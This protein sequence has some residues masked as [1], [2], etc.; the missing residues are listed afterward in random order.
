VTLVRVN[1][2]DALEAGAYVVSPYTGIPFMPLRVTE[3]MV[4][5]T[6]TRFVRISRGGLGWCPQTTYWHA[7]HGFKWDRNRHAWY[8]TKAPYAKWVRPTLAE[9]GIEP[10]PGE[11]LTHIEE[12]P[13]AP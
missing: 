10:V 11:Q 3:S 9:L 5:H 12:E 4:S 1:N 2:D 6:G 7:P 13:D 8:A